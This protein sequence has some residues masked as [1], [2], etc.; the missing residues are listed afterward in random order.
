MVVDRKDPTGA[1]YLILHNVGAGPRIED[2]LF[3]WRIVG[4]YRYVPR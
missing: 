1:R 4:H 3:S 2:A